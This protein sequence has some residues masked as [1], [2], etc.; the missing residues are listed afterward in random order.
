MSRLS[1]LLIC[2]AVALPARA[3]A[4]GEGGEGG[5]SPDERAVH[6]FTDLLRMEPGAMDPA[7]SSLTPALPLLWNDDLHAAARFYAEDMVE[8]GCFPANHSSC[9][10]TP[11][12]DRVSSFYVGEGIG[13]NIA[14]GYG[15]ARS[16]VLDGWLYSD[17]HRA[18]LMEPMWNELGTGFASGGPGPTWVQDFGVR[19]GLS[20]E[21]ITSAT[22][23]PLAAN[24]GGSVEFFAAVHDPAGAISGL[25]IA[26]ADRCEPMDTFLGD[27]AT[28]GWQA[29]VSD[30]P[31]GCLAYWFVAER[32]SGDLVRY[33]STGALV[34][35]VGTSDCEEFQVIAPS[36]DCAGSAS[37]DDDDDGGGG[38]GGR[39]GAGCDT[40]P[41][42]GPDSAVED[43]VSYGSCAVGGRPL[44]TALVGVLLLSARRRRAEAKGRSPRG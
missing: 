29:E 43:E 17:G 6:L 35:P 16:V 41:S 8:N 28:G 36:S 31:A 10:G 15:D 18:N 14:Q 21:V 37:G 22:A 34:L 26:V 42:E 32:A 13:E 27:D 1:L 33:P 9:D 3:V 5:P 30:L 25:S 20:R 39:R 7:W 40:A 12:G 11:F 2:L 44:G 19:S 24:E 4:Y 23:W 38:G